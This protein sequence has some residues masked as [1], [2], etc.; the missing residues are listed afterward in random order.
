MGFL[1]EGN[2][3][4]LLSEYLIKSSVI[5]S[6]SIMLAFIMRKKSAGLRHLVLSIFL[7]G[8]L[9]LPIIS[10]VTTGW[11][12]KLLPAWQTTGAATLTTESLIPNM[13]D[14]SMALGASFADS[15]IPQQVKTQKNAG[16]FFSMVLSKLKP[17]FGLAALLVW[18]F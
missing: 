11:E 8:L 5:L 10:T 17:L 13:N 2:G 12:T 16:S 18:I 7:V 6:V 3:L 4:T 15:D 14:S 1:L 9:F